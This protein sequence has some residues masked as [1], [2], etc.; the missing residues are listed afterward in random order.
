M[1]NICLVGSVYYTLLR[2]HFLLRFTIITVE[3]T[4]RKLDVL[5]GNCHMYAR[6]DIKRQSCVLKFSLPYFVVDPK[7]HLVG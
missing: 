1:N 5:I 3:I 6:N 4:D 2:Y 7:G